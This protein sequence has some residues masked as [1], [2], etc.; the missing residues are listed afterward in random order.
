MNDPSVIVVGDTTPDHVK[1]PPQLGGLEVRVLKIT[2]A[3]CP[4]CAVPSPICPTLVL[5]NDMY[6]T[7]SCPIHSFVW[8]RR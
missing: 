6:V 5:E 3:P 2:D 7:A 4:K 8:Y 1:L